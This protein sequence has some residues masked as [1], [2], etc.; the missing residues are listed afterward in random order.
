MNI[1]QLRSISRTHLKLTLRARTTPDTPRVSAIPPYHPDYD[2]AQYEEDDEVYLADC[3]R[4][5]EYEK[6]GTCAGVARITRYD[7]ELFPAK[8]CISRVVSKGWAL[9]SVCG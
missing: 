3:K 9:L 2:S 1:I 4:F 5:I 8:Y 6:G 7:R